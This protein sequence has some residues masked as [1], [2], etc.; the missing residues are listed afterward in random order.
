MAV[1][2][3]EE[4]RGDTV[5]NVHHGHVCV[6]DETGNMAWSAGDPNWLAYMRS[7]AK[8]IQAIPTFVHGF[9]EQFGLTDREKTIMTASHLA[10][11]IHV[12]ALESMLSKIDVNEA[13]LVCAESYPPRSGARDALLLAGKPKRKLYHNCSGKHLGIQALCK[14]KGYPLEGY[15]LPDHPAQQEVMEM[16]T[17]LSGL[18]RDDV[19]LGTDG[20]GFPVFGLPLERLARMYLKL[21]CPDLID[22]PEVSGAIRKL[23]RL[24]NENPEMVSAPGMICSELLKDPNIVAKGGAKGVYCFGLRKERLGIA[25]KVMDGSDEE[26]PLI[27][28]SILEQIGYDNQDTID[29][30]NQL[31]P[32]TIRNDA[33]LEV[34]RNDVVF[35]LQR[36]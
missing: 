2:L 27:I 14:G 3:I 5:E 35:H 4:Y 29:R 24:M 26:W 15:H 8:P 22:R 6:V 12:E 19:K 13:G 11:E 30:L 21:A 23:T 25:L 9:D 34:G 31:A 36:H 18:N 7:T 1:R 28:V 32:R 16:V 10:E 17:L 20:C 33:G